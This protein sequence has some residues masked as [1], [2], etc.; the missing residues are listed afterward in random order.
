M[1]NANIPFIYTK[2]ILVRGHGSLIK[3]FSAKDVKYCSMKN[4]NQAYAYERKL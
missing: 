1:R 4:H 3:Y 2:M